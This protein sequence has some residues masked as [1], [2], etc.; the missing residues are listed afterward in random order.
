MRVAIFCEYYYPFVSGVVTH[1]E[2]LKQGLIAN[3]HEVLIV[4]LDPKARVHYIK[5][6]V[7][8]CPAIPLKRIYGYGLGNPVNLGRLAILRDF[9]PD[10]IHLHTEF[11]MG[12]FAMFTARRLKKPVVYTLHT[13]YD[14]YIFYLFPEKMERMAKMAKPAAHFYIRRVASNATEIIGPSVKVVNYLRRCGV[15]RH[16]NIVPNSVD[17][18]AFL[19]EN[20]A[21]AD[22]DAVKKELGITPD[23]VALCFVGRLGKEKSIDVL[24]N[25]FYAGFGG[26]ENFQLLLIG[27]GPEKDDLQ[28]QIDTLGAGKQVKLLGKIDHEK[29]PAYYQACDLFATASLTEMNSISLLEATAS[30]LYAVHRLDVFNRDQ[31]QSGKNG[32]VFTTDAEFADIVGAY[33]ALSPEERARRKADVSTFARRYGRDEFTQ[34]ILNVYTRAQAEYRP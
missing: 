10:I 29:L 6:D 34:A 31:I 18:T 8:Y 27:D 32:D 24:I 21:Q 1:I 30:G 19:P 25:T 15:T 17:M 22:V 20:V 23:T 7:L 26:K 5:D 16:I 28:Q 14:E 12:I 2:T 9:N 4:T 3:G 13:M 11:S 33:A